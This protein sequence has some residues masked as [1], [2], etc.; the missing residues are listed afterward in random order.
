[1]VGHLQLNTALVSPLFL[2]MEKPEV[3][4]QSLPGCVLLVNNW[5]F[6]NKNMPIS[7]I[8]FMKEDLM[9]ENLI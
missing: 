6:A 9:E 5:M 8:K 1:M 4:S 7:A 2:N 3:I